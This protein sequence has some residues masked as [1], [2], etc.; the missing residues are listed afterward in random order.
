MTLKK[1]LFL[2]RDGVIN[3]NH[4]YVHTAEQCEFV[5][6]IQELLQT[7]KEKGYF[8]VVVTNQSGIGRGY[9]SEQQFH[10]F[11]AWMNK[12]LDGVLDAVYFCPFHP[13]Q[14]IGEYRKDSPNRKPNAGMLLQAIDEHKIDPSQSLLIGDSEKDIIA[15]ERANLA[16]AFYYS[17]TPMPLPAI[18]ITVSSLYEVVNYL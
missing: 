12:Q 9:Y 8:I 5:A 10:R 17:Q 1:A 13:T 18:A 16:Q 6:G 4:G 15:A 3:V 11:M 14:A 7:A 2:D